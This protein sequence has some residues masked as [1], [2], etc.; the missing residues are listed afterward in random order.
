MKLADI[1]QQI[2]DYYQKFYEELESNKEDLNFPVF[3]EPNDKVWS[4]IFGFGTVVSILEDTNDFFVRFDN[5]PEELKWHTYLGE[6]IKE[7]SDGETVYLELVT[8]FQV[9][10]DFIEPIIPVN[11]IKNKF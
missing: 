1:K 8:L 2:D 9:G 11:I 4:F 3:F 5:I 6:Y 10:D 7:F